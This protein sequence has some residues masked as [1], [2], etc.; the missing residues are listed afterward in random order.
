MSPLGY[1]EVAAETQYFEDYKLGGH[2]LLPFVHLQGQGPGVQ[3][4]WPRGLW[5]SR[6]TYLGKEVRVNVHHPSGG[7]IS[8]RRAGWDPETKQGRQGE[9]SGRGGGRTSRAVLGTAREPS[10]PIPSLSSS[11]P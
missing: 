7:G 4:L 1:A 6:L 3:S 10:S 5:L 9:P 2:C 8:V 11:L